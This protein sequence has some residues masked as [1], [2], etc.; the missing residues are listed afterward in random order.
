MSHPTGRQAPA[1]MHVPAQMQ[2]ASPSTPSLTLGG[3]SLLTDDLACRISGPDAMIA[4]VP[5]LVG[6]HPSDSMVI[7]WLRQQRVVLTQ[8]VD[9][10][11]AGADIDA[12]MKTTVG[13]A[14]SAAADSAVVIVFGADP[15]VAGSQPASTPDEA[16]DSGKGVARSIAVGWLDDLAAVVQSTMMAE[17]V[18][19]LDVLHVFEDRWWSYLCQSDCCPSSGRPLNPQV[20]ADVARC[21]AG[22]GIEPASSRQA[23]VA[24]L[25]S[26]PL[27][28]ARVQPDVTRIL[29]ELHSRMSAASAPTDE[30]EQWRSEQISSLVP[31][32]TG[33]VAGAQSA[34]DPGPA[35]LDAAR[36]GQ[37]LV[38]LGDIR[39]RD[40][41]LWH[42][43]ASR[44]PANCLALL[45]PVLRAAVPG[46]VAPIATCT[47]I[48]AWLVGD[49]VRAS[50]A[51]QRA[52]GDDGEYVLGAL[53]ARS[54]AAGLAPGAWREVMA[55]VSLDE[56]R[57]GQPKP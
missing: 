15:R 43:A 22:S 13:I 37:L 33:G 3:D 19:C 18:T 6:F 52:L 54:L 7:V 2:A 31:I 50:T 30:I 8:R 10:P 12:E 49:G 35:A 27:A 42:L 20:Q 56:C 9:L 36:T 34:D 5:F 1:K 55:R 46:L 11:P 28:V 4:A 26:D 47:A 24:S 25:E 44:E 48:A 53:V 51:A 17:Q 40:T 57:T 41:L 21:L 14:R 29:G 45:M 32:F 16:V 38:A 23:V 39:V